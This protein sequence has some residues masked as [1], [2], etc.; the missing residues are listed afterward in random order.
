MAPSIIDNAFV[1][2]P[3]PKLGKYFPSVNQQLKK[4]N[5]AI[6]IN[7]KKPVRPLVDD[8]PVNLQRASILPQNAG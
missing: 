2:P 8:V 4:W 5:N 3:F 1:N 7:E 6:E